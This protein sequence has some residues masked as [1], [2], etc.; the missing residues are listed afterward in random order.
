MSLKVDHEIETLEAAAQAQDES[1]F[2]RAAKPIDW[3][4]RQPDDLLRAIRLALEAGAHIAARDLSA[5]GAGLFPHD[6]R[7]RQFAEI[8]APP[9]VI[10]TRPARDSGIRAN[11]DWLKAHSDEYRGKWVGLHKGV[12]LGAAD[13]LD[14]LKKR[15]LIAE[16]TLI[17]RVY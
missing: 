7:L 12:L 8:L 16:D 10:G 15:G 9:R 13:S 17:T 4:S 11:R 6:V 1:G 14:E 2:V 3:Q 5:L